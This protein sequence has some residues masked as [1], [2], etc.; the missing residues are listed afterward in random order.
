MRENRYLYTWIGS[1][2]LLLIICLFPFAYTQ[3]RIDSQKLPLAN[4]VIMLDPGH[5]GPDGGAIGKNGLIEK[6][7]TLSI[8]KY[9]RDYLQE[10]GAWVVMSREHDQDLAKL[11]TKGLSKRKA[12]DLQARMKMVK[13]KRVDTLISIHL[14]AFPQTEYAGAQTFY[15]PTK[16]ENKILATS[17]QKQLVRLLENTDR[18]PKQKNDTYLLKE[19]PVPTALIEAGFLSN[20]QEAQLLS[21]PKYQKKIAASIYYGLVSYYGKMRNES[22]K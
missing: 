5:G 22:G 18:L 8:A 20:P 2:L 21:Q 4:K 7:L 3:A 11:E 6:Y 12:E 19:S 17:I 15:N 9:L 16:E 14:N 1:S 13:N 10:G